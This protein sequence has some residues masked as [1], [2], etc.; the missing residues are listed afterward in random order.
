MNVIPSV[1]L[2]NGS[3][4][5]IEDGR[6]SRYSENGEH[7]DMWDLMGKL[8][9]YNKV[10]LLDL[11][12]IERNRPNFDIIQKVSARKDIWADLGA[13]SAETITDTFIA[14][15]DRAVVSTRT[16]SSMDL[17]V[18]A[19]ELSRKIIFTIVVGEGVLSMSKEI[20]KGSVKGLVSEGVDHGVDKIV[21]IDLS[22][23]GFKDDLIYDLP[24]E[25]YELYIGGIDKDPEYYE[26]RVDGVM[27]GIKEA[28]GYQKKS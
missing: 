4:V 15:A 7:I 8:G 13:R 11:N 16:M 20:K 26:D 21:V 28:I 1:T 9:D 23:D 25:D 24:E 18:D 14:G 5:V 17:L 27:L 22:Q 3:P 10:Y 2:K 19:L 12:G 6:Y